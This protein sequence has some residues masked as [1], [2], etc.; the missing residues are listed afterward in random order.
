MAECIFKGGTVN[1]KSE[2]PI[3]PICKKRRTKCIG[4]KDGP[5]ITEQKR[6]IKRQTK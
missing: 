4:E 1:Q 3:T 6:I 2:R 5:I